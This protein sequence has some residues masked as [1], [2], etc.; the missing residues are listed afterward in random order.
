[1]VL[2]AAFWKGCTDRRA[3]GLIEWVR[4]NDGHFV[5]RPGANGRPARWF[6]PITTAGI[7]ECA[8]VNG[9]RLTVRRPQRIGEPL[10][11]ADMRRIVNAE[12]QVR[13]VSCLA[14]RVV[15]GWTMTGSPT[16]TTS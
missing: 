5:H 4:G 11:E 15:Y 10:N 3:S 1:M 14:S 2:T 9:Y 7:A 13:S 8:H 6:R 16:W 12:F